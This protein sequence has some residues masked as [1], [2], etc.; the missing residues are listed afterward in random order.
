M[1][2]T[3]K[4]NLVD[5]EINPDTQII[6]QPAA[7]TYSLN[8]YPDN[9]QTLNN[10]D[11]FTDKDGV[12]VSGKKAYFN[13]EFF[14]VD[15]L[16]SYN[17]KQDEVI[18]HHKKETF[19]YDKKEGGIQFTTY[20]QT[21]IPEDKFNAGIFVQLSLPRYNN[22]TNYQALS[23]PEEKTILNKLEKDLKD[24]A[25]IKCNVWNSYL[26][27]IDTFSNLYTEENFNSYSNLFQVLNASR[28]EK[29]EYANETFL[30]KNNERQICIYNKIA[31]MINKIKDKNVYGL[32]PANVMRIE[33]RYIKKRKIQSAL[34]FNNL[35][36]LYSNYD[37]LKESYRSDIE[38]TIFKYDVTEVER[39]TG[40]FIKEDMAYFYGKQSR[41]WLSNYLKMF[42]VASLLKLSNIE[43]IIEKINE[44][45]DS[46]VNKSYKNK[47]MIKS[48]IKLMMEEL[49]FK[50]ESTKLNLFSTIKTNKDL[51]NELKTKFHKL[52]A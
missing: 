46:D 1:I 49:R 41:Q 13:S 21:K 24:K 11:L 32:I 51:Y 34:S 18:K 29:F 2:D 36:D 37:Y 50:M 19:L 45:I 26:S 33:N 43:T 31:E 15:I 23:I 3:I 38:K 4:L 27:R 20:S 30:Y 17:L 22:K 10:Y 42:G 9:K 39:M 12:I 48:R 35:K 25:G 52:A 28:L 47:R 40:K 7:Y 44:I 16:P 8:D 5:C 14:N 6:I